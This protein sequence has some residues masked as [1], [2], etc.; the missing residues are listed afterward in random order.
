[1]HRKHCVR[2]EIWVPYAYQGNRLCISPTWNRTSDMCQDSNQQGLVTNMSESRMQRLCAQDP[3][4]KGYARQGWPAEVFIP[5]TSWINRR[6]PIANWTSL[7]KYDMCGVPSATQAQSAGSKA[8]TEAMRSWQL[9][10]VQQ[11]RIGGNYRELRERAALL[12]RNSMVPE[13]SRS[14][15]L[16]L[17]S[18]PD[19]FHA[20]SLFPN[21]S[22][23]TMLAS[24]PFGDPTLFFSNEYR[25]FS[26][27]VTSKFLAMWRF[28]GY[29]WTESTWMN[30][31][32]EM[33]FARVDGDPRRFQN[34]PMG[35]LPILLLALGILGHPIVGIDRPP[36]NAYARLLCPTMSVRYVVRHLGLYEASHS[37]A[38]ELDELGELLAADDSSSVE[39]HITFIKA[40]DPG[41]VQD[42]LLAPLFRTW[43]LNASAAVINDETG[44]QPSDFGP[45]VPESIPGVGVAPLASD[46]EVHTYGN[47]SSLQVCYSE[48]MIPKWWLQSIN[49]DLVPSKRFPITPEACLVRNG[50]LANKSAELHTIYASA[51]LPFAFGYGLSCANGTLGGGVMMVAHRKEGMPNGGAAVVSLR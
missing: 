21:A 29:S 49:C 25:E 34:A 16:Y 44:L 28:H 12:R 14:P 3:R 19:I 42:I 27:N 22:R 15:V 41:N 35:V 17:F 5:M 2:Y 13:L 31:N 7:Y 20:A 30:R 45:T 18:G 24:V 23:Y 50:K 40:A 32:L 4:C 9:L 8:L 1:M 48:Q 51:E 6:P 36:S 39:R 37:M 11:A 33:L 38:D 47:F 46:W 26:L 43:L 10:A